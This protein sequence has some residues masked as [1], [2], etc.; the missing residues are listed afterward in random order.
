MTNVQIIQKYP[1]LQC[2]DY[3][4]N[5]ILDDN[6][7]PYT[8]L[9]GNGWD[10]LILLFSEELLP[11]Y[12]KM[13]EESKKEFFITDIKEKWGL[14]DISLSCYNDEIID[15]ISKYEHLS[16]FVCPVC[17]SVKLHFDKSE[18]YYYKN[19]FGSKLCKKCDKDETDKIKIKFEDD[20]KICALAKKL[21]DYY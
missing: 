14:L 19:S 2:F 1:F 3:C 10:K 20:D 17:G 13:S 4:G 5:S 8:M 18:P 15:L 7:I 9:L 16:K 11:I 12:N 6:G 21:D